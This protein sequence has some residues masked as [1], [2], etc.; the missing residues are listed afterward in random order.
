[1]KSLTLRKEAEEDIQIA[2][3][4]YNS[5][6]DGLGAD[7]LLCVE[8]GLS[9]I[10]RNSKQFPSL[11]R[12]IRRTFIHRFPFGIYYQETDNSILVFAVLHVRRSPEHLKS[13]IKSV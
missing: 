6:R 7:F 2:Y 4:W 11:Y 5:K 12:E 8:E 3:D 1:M 10:D 9:R 13:R